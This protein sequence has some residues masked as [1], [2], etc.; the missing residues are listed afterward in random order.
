MLNGT[1]SNGE[2]LSDL[3]AKIEKINTGLTIGDKT[4]SFYDSTG[5]GTPI[6]IVGTEN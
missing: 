5:K 2:S 6:T 4:Y 3:Y 1:G